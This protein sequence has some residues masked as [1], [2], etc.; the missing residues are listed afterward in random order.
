MFESLTW[1]MN[2]RKF[3]RSIEAQA[4]QAQSA[5]DA[6]RI[7]RSVLDFAAAHGITY[8][9]TPTVVL[10]SVLAL[11]A[12]G[13]SVL[14]PHEQGYAAFFALLTVLTPA[15]AWKFR[16]TSLVK[17][18]RTLYRV[19]VYEHNQMTLHAENS[20]ERWAQLKARF[21]DFRRGDEDQVID[22]WGK[23]CIT[24]ADKRYSCE[25]YRFQY[26]DVRK[27]TETVFVASSN[28]YETRTKTVRETRYR[29]GLIMPFPRAGRIMMSTSG[30][31]PYRHAWRTGSPSFD[32]LF[33][34]TAEDQFNA[35]KIL[36]PA[37]LG[38]LKRTAQLAD[39]A[40][41]IRDGVLC[42]SHS[43][44]D[45]LTMQR[46]VTLENPWGVLEAVRSPEE[47]RYREVLRTLMP[48]FQFNDD[49]FEQVAQ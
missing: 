33:T 3:A 29:S 44:N 38:C 11:I 36:Q 20:A 5:A 32:S 28:S 7:L 25:L 23:G 15:V 49:N 31:K 35:A 27:V 12:A 30:L 42:L 4:E 24:A 9:W 19:S 10:T 45:W 22:G 43:N 18:A 41:E 2:L 48:L 14:M 21:V 1:N 37:V 40:L 47:L 17:P 6:E 34:V 16:R 8:R 46:E 13:C 39:V 26:V